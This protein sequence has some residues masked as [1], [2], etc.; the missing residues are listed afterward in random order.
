MRGCEQ[1]YKAS[2]NTQDTRGQNVTAK[3]KDFQEETYRRQTLATR[4]KTS[5]ENDSKCL[6]NAI[7]FHLKGKVVLLIEKPKF[8]LSFPGK[9]NWGQIMTSSREYGLNKEV[10]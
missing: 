7:S 3:E 10:R 8:P 5:A 1:I 6:K 4:I 9:V 2:K